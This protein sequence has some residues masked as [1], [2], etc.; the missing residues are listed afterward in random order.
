MKTF[1]YLSFSLVLCCSS[2]PINGF[3]QNKYHF[4]I[5]ARAKTNDGITDWYLEKFDDTR[6][7]LLLEMFRLSNTALDSV[8]WMD[9]TD[10]VDLLTEFDQDFYSCKIYY[11]EKDN[12]RIQTK[13]FPGRNKLGG[14]LFSLFISCEEGSSLMVL[15]EYY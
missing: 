9:H 15:T 1:F 12:I 11:T 5:P 3:S 4:D 14:K 6:D 10:L 2:L 8:I 13:T 7:S